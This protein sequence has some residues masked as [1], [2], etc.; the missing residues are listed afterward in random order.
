MK[1]LFFCILFFISIQAVAK[2]IVFTEEEKEFIKNTPLV[3]VGMMPDF[4]PFSYYIKNTPVGFEHELLNILSQ[5]TGLVF[6][7]EY[8]KWTTIY[9]AFKNKEVDVITSISHKKYR[10]PFTT[11]TSSYYDIPI[12]IFVRDDFGEYLGIKSLEGKKVGVLKDVFY[13]KELQKIDNINLVYYDTY[14][15]LTKDLVFGKIDALMQNLTNINYLIKK[16]LY[17]NLKLASELILPNTKKEDLRLGVIPEKP[18]LSSIL[19]KGLNSITK[20]EKEAL[21]NK[22]IGSIKEYKGGHIELNKDERAYLN[23]KTIKYCINPDGLPF[24]GLNEKNE[25]SGISSDYYSLFEN[26]LSAKFELVRTENWNQSIT[27]I[28]EK[29]CDMLALGMETY[30]RKKYL[31]FTSNYLNVPL[32][33]A[34]KV[35]VPF[36]NHILDLEGEKVG[37]IKGDA[38]VKILRQKY[39]SLDLVEVEDIN[40]G[41]DKVKSGK[42]FGFIDTLASIGY[43]FQHKYFGELKIA[44]K[45][46]ETLELSMAVVK[47]DEV[48]LNILQKAINSMT[49][50]MHREIFSKWIPIKY[51]KGVNYELVWKI[52]I[53]SLIVILLV[54]Y[55]NRKIIKT[56]RL[57]EEAQK[58][59]EEKNKE[60]KKL[61]TTD[62]LTNLYNR[63]KIEELLEFEINRS[64]R[65]N[66]NFGLAIVDIDKF[67]EVNDT[68]GHQVGDKVLKELANILNTNRRK[69]DFVGRY[70]GEEFVIICPESDVQGVIK[71]METF[72]EKICNYKFSKVENKTASFGVTMSQRGDTIESILKRADDALYQAKDNGRN[73]IEYK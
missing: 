17:S 59:I 37:I 44:G 15:E 34:T 48:L 70:G 24:E 54:V 10:E 65:F 3:K 5:R 40:E 38:F 7:K 67:K 71:L 8:A 53:G 56:N 39:P 49:N 33:V 25:H 64:E 6:E 55:W 46:N 9:T 63:R 27:F 32:V 20:K 22:W 30:E 23:T 51:E 62:K 18:I 45:I 26:I 72:K 28:K 52:A 16:N 1:T 31:N 29:K 57:L 60:L 41:L 61:A 14:E 2:P 36:I 13:I 73:K 35:D 47:E 12:M 11:F 69:T 43:E 21:V 19:Q 42:L 4:T 50:D 66:H 58:D 68:Y